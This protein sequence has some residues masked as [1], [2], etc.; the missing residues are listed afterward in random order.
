MVLLFGTLMEFF[1]NYHDKVFIALTVSVT[2]TH[3]LNQ[4]H[5]FFFYHYY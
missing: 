1:N 4:C 3:L 2:Q 5:A